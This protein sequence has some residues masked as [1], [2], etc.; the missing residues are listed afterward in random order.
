MKNDFHKFAEGLVASDEHPGAEAGDLQ[1][2][3]ADFDASCREASREMEHLSVW[4]QAQQK[5]LKSRFNVFTAVLKYDDEVKLHSRWLHYLLNPKGEH[6][7]DT[8]FLRVFLETL[9]KEGVQRHKDGD[10]L[11]RMDA[12]ETF[13][14]ESAE[15]KKEHHTTFGNLDILIECPGWGVIVVENKTRLWEGR[16]QIRD[17]ANYCIKCC[18]H[19]DH[20]FFLLFLTPE[21]DS[22]QTAHEHDDKYRRISYRKHILSWLEECLR[23]T[24]AYVHINQ[25][26]QQYRNVVNQLLKLSSDSAYMN[27]LTTILKKHPIIIKHRDD[28][29]Q[30]IELMRQNYW[31]SFVL[32]LREQL[33]ELGITL[34]QKTG[35]KHYT[36]FDLETSRGFQRNSYPELRTTLEYWEDEN[37]LLIGETVS[38]PDSEIRREFQEKK[39][40]FVRLIERL[41][42]EFPQAYNSADANEGWPL[43]WAELL[44]GFMLPEFLAKHATQDSRPMSEQVEAVVRGISRYLKVLERAWPEAA[45]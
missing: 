42:K 15:V 29:N 23:A 14:S 44:K 9:R 21:G 7:C 11:D 10:P 33:G 26:L 20:K 41:D 25:A 27:G 3:L 38:S 43:G 37:C 4:Q 28:I 34:G 39:V 16:N 40:K 12:L 1:P 36:D 19:I 5:A 2:G 17:Y 30:A 13:A 45:A 18:S 35:D 22:S 32:E 8:L 6:D 31:A 24:Y